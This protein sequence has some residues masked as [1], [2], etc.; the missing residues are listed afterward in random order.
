[1]IHIAKKSCLNKPL[2]TYT[3]PLLQR[4]SHRAE[5]SYHAY[6]EHQS[7]RLFTH[8]QACF[9]NRFA[10]PHFPISH[11]CC[12]CPVIWK[13][14]TCQI[15]FWGDIRA[16]AE[17]RAGS[18]QLEALCSTAVSL[19]MHKLPNVMRNMLLGELQKILQ[20]GLKHI[21]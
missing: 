2:S 8:L 18:A 21:I 12:K 16:S 17:L 7:K 6:R 4:H 3:P 19:K 20:A 15:R 9:S 1:M 10:S 11:Y 5:T 14:H 13:T